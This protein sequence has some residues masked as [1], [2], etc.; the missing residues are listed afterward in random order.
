MLFSLI[1]TVIMHVYVGYIYIYIMQSTL[2]MNKNRFKY[3]SYN[4]TGISKI[5]LISVN[6]QN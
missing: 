6:S 5:Y 2:K 3:L 4:T 1:Q